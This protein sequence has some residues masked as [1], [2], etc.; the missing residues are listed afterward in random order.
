M[1]QIILEDS[2]LRLNVI[3]HVFGVDKY[4]RIRENLQVLLIYLK[5][6]AKIIQGEIKSIDEDKVRVESTKSF[7]KVL[8]DKILQKGIELLENLRKRK[9]G[10]AS[11]RER[12]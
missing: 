6:N 3:R 1:K 8:D 10:R 5:E 4:K 2:E 7:I 9:I 12:V 11:C